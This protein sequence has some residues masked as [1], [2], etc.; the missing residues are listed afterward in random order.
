MPD[1]KVV[2]QESEVRIIN[3]AVN[4]DNKQL[5]DNELDQNIAQQELI[6][7]LE[8]PS[9]KNK[10]LIEDKNIRQ[11]E[12]DSNYEASSE[13]SKQLINQKVAE[14]DSEIQML[15]LKLKELQKEHKQL[16]DAHSKVKIEYASLKK[17]EE[18]ELVKNKCASLRKFEEQELVKS[19]FASLG[20]VREQELGIMQN[21]LLTKTGMLQYNRNMYLYTYEHIIILE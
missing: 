1:Q 16:I 17:V 2:R 21:P 7:K 9:S 8:A 18:Q 11:Q 12:L 5:I 6:S 19:E 4:K 3:E 20:K 14:Q 13:G 15:N 10:Q